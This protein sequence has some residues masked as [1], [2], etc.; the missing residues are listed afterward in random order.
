MI[1]GNAA[2]ARRQ[3]V[4]HV[5][6]RIG[7]QDG[8][9]VVVAQLLITDAAVVACDAVMTAGH[10]EALM[11]AIDAVVWSAIESQIVSARRSPISCERAKA[12]PASAPKTSKRRSGAPPRARPRSCRSTAT[13]TSSASGKSARCCV[14]LAP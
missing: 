7:R 6:T 9:L 1:F 10:V 4:L 12:R 14:S 2:K 5:K 8:F 11:F 3:L 13:A